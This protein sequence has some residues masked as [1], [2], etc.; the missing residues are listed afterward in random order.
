MV[1]TV[2]LSRVLASVLLVVAG[3]SQTWG[4]AALLLVA[5]Y[6]SNVLDDRLVH[7]WQIDTPANYRLRSKASAVLTFCTLCAVTWG[8]LWSRV[9]LLVI[10]VWA[11]I[12]WLE[13]RLRGD[14]LAS[15][16]LLPPFVTLGLLACAEARIMRAAWSVPYAA[17]ASALILAAC[18]LC[19]T[20]WDRVHTFINY[21]LSEED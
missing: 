8:G 18:C 14:W 13:S 5:G 20:E 15:A 11:L 4:W 17:S 3:V 1:M 6:A 19:Y 16:R 21:A 12:R 10:P 9:I 7:Q 2:A